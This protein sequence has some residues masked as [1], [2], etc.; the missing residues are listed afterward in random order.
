M[1]TMMLVASLLSLASG[2][3]TVGTPGV[4]VATRGNLGALVAKA[5][6]VDGYTGIARVGSSFRDGAHGRAR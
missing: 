6:P 2:C 5:A 4:K 1:K 3:S